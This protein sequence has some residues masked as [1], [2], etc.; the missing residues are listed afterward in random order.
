MIKLK[1]TKNITFEQI[2]IILLISYTIFNR[3]VEQSSSQR[4]LLATQEKAKSAEA[5]SQQAIQRT[6]AVEN[7]TQKTT[8][9]IVELQAVN[10]STLIEIE[11]INK[12]YKAKKDSLYDNLDTRLSRVRQNL[13]EIQKLQKQL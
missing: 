5:L 1:E 9:I 10:N 7:I 8:E 13:K 3:L 6:Q 2:M 11:E 12:R 4:V